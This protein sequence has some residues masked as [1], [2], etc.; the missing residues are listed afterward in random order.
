MN[1]SG[2]LASDKV[3]EI[4]DFQNW[5]GCK[6]RGFEGTVNGFDGTVSPGATTPPP[7]TESYR[8]FAT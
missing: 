7:H 6:N 8:F 1:N 3:L 5:A 4:I 2:R